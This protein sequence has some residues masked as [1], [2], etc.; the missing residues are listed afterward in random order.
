V[1]ARFRSHRHNFADGPLHS[2][3]ARPRGK[4]SASEATPWRPPDR[5]S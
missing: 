2:A 4:V 5:A 1:G 3:Q